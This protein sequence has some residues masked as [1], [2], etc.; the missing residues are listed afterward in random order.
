MR[1]HVVRHRPPLLGNTEGTRVQFAVVVFIVHGSERVGAW[2]EAIEGRDQPVDLCD[3][4]RCKVLDEQLE[5]NAVEQPGRRRHGPL[6]HAAL[7]DLGVELVS[8]NRCSCSLLQLRSAA[9]VI[10]MCMRQQQEFDLRRQYALLCERLQNS[11]A[12]LLETCVHKRVSEAATQ[13][14]AI[15]DTEVERLDGWAKRLE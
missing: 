6:M 15:S 7:D 1:R 2:L 14:E 10:W 12:M 8:D 9:R 5:A 3:R 13:Q 4:N 11:V